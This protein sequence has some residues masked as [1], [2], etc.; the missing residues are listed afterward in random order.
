M[1]SYYLTKFPDELPAHATG[2]CWRGDVCRYCYRPNIAFLRTLQHTVSFLVL[3]KSVVRV[4]PEQQPYPLPLA[5][6]MCQQDMKHFQHSRL[7]LLH[8]RTVRLNIPLE[9]GSMG[10]KLR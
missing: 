5:R 2:A 6:R 9:S 8:P 1:L 3:V 7:A 10:L 4:L